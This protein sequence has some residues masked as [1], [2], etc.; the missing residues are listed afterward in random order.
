MPWPHAHP[1]DEAIDRARDELAAIRASQPDAVN[2]AQDALAKATVKLHA[3]EMQ[4]RICR[5]LGHDDTLALLAV[6][7]AQAAVMVAGDLLIEALD[8]AAGRSG[9][10]A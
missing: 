5:R 2:A 7:T 6:E 9:R 1:E 4:L 8:V 10:A 3:A